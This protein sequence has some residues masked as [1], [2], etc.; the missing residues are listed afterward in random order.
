MPRHPV[1]SRYRRNCGLAVADLRQAPG[2]VRVKHE[3]DHEK[4]YE[5]S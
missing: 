1:E 3:K 5:K 4:R 2:V